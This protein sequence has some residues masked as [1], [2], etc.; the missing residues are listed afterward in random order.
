MTIRPLMAM[1]LS[2]ALGA[3]LSAVPAAARELTVATRSAALLTAQR[4]AY[5]T[6]FVQATGVPIH[7]QVWEGGLD[8]LRSKLPVW[9]LVL[10]DGGE[11]LGACAGGLLMKLDWS[12]IGGRDHYLPQGASDCGVGA[13]AH[14]V[15]LA[16]DRDK[17]QG[18]PS[19]ADFWDVAKYPG[20][21]ALQQGARM[22]L[23]IALMADG[24][25]PGDVYRTLRTDE[26]VDRAFRKLEQIKP[27]LVWWK[28]PEEAPKL[29]GSG[30]VL[31][32]TAP[33]ER[34]AAANQ[35]GGHHFGVQ[36]P[37]SL[38]EIESW[39]IVKGS[40]NVVDAQK[41]LALMGEPAREAKFA[42]I[43]SLGVLAK[44]ATDALT[45]EQLALSPGNPANLSAALQIDDQ[46][47]N[48]NLEK[49]NRRFDAWV[50]H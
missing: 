7:E 35:A 21:R 11:L 6:P 49:L 40:P 46:F 37:G 38:Y 3:P 41:L 26:G 16:W 36:L 48:D 27:Y 20:K 12:A 32:T 50:A 30:D 22:N 42:S 14:D 43:A 31:L 13:A 24:V 9:D 44:G 17:F 8:T 39:G 47:W 5:F 4:E 25:A 19:W 15:A 28:S 2:M 29:L 10:V 45:P 23:E 18:T 1:A 33:S 34:I